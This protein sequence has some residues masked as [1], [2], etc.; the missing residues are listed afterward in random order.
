MDPWTGK[1]LSALS[2]S[3]WCN[4][5]LGLTIKWTEKIKFVRFLKEPNK[6]QT[7]TSL[8]HTFVLHSNNKP[9]ADNLKTLRTASNKLKLPPINPWDY[10]VSKET[11]MIITYKIINWNLGL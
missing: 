9:P 11:Y 2:Q 10:Y 3:Y 1:I 5:A 6:H 4:Y 7:E 8:L